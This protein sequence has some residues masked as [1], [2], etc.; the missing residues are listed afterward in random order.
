MNVQIFHFL[1]FVVLYIDCPWGTFCLAHLM[2]EICHQ[3]TENSHKASVHTR[4]KLN[5]S[6]SFEAKQWSC[7]I[8]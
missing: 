6:E 4:K 7:D 8:Q 1:V 2:G 3:N 5:P